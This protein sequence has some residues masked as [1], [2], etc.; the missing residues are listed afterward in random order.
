MFAAVVLTACGATTASA[1]TLSPAYPNP[2]FAYPNPAMS[3]SVSF[4]KDV[5][6]IFESSCFKCHGGEKTEKGLDLKTYASVMLGSQKGAVITP[7]NADNS[8]LFKAVSSGKMPKRG[9]KLTSGQLDLIKNW[10][11]SGA[12]N[13]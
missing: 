9:A 1:P 5:L 2:N 12:P 8:V 4:A 10:I 3:G 13:H 6:P 11:N 7:G